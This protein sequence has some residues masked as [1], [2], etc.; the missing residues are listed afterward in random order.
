MADDLQT[1]LRGSFQKLRKALNLISESAHIFCRFACPLWRLEGPMEV[2]SQ[3][4]YG[5]RWKTPLLPEDGLLNNM[6]AEGKASAEVPVRYFDPA[7]DER[8]KISLA[9][10]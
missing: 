2:W 3:G 6:A 7:F 1:A 9:R 5:K 10:Y 4:L 8:K